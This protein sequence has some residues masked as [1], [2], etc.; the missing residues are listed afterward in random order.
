MKSR[1]LYFIFLS[2]CVCCLLLSGCQ[3][4]DRK[5][6]P[7]VQTEPGNGADSSKKAPDDILQ[8]DQES[9]SD[10]IP[11]EPDKIIVYYFH[12][13]ARCKACLD[14]ER[15][16]RDTTITSFSGPIMDGQIEWRSVN[17][18][19]SENKELC[20]RFDLPNPSLVLVFEASG[21]T[22]DWKVLGSTWD[23]IHSPDEFRGYV[24]SEIDQA[25]TGLAAPQGAP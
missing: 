9:I 19:N 10:S 6:A 12:G 13:T 11:K 14:I 15:L 24:Q 7:I 22:V 4:N 23:L 16:A 17:Y 8:T 20:A 5:N 18:D 25:F 3:D 1:S 21:F 2:I